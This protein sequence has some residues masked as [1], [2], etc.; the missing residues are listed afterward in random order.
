MEAVISSWQILRNACYISSPFLHILTFSSRSFVQNNFCWRFSFLFFL[1][2]S[3]L[4]AFFFFGQK[5]GQISVAS[6]WQKRKRAYFKF[7]TT[8]KNLIWCPKEQKAQTVLPHWHHTCRDLW[9]NLV[10]SSQS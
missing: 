7:L 4:L 1:I 6:I 9:C 3:F 8:P 2:F 10:P 5:E